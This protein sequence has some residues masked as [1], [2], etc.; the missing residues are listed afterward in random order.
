MAEFLNQLQLPGWSEYFS[1][2]TTTTDFFAF[3]FIFE[4][5]VLSPD[6]SYLA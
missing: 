3:S 5:F 1:K 6:Q 2:G 4:T